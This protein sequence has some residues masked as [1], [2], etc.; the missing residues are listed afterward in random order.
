VSGRYTRRT[1]AHELSPVA[2]RPGGWKKGPVT[3]QKGGARASGQ[4][5]GHG[6][7]SSLSARFAWPTSCPLRWS[8]YSLM[9]LVKRVGKRSER[10]TAVFIGAEPTPRPLAPRGRLCFAQKGGRQFLPDLP[11]AARK[12]ARALRAGRTALRADGYKHSACASLLRQSV[13][14]PVLPPLAHSRP[15]LSQIAIAQY[16]GAGCAGS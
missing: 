10:V 11:L 3:R 14:C 6:G 16:C 15:Q 5:V 2:C 4:E 9:L 7:R 12:K 8:R 1:H 13:G